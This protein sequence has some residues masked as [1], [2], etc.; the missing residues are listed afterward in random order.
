MATVKQGARIELKALGDAHAAM[1]TG[2]YWA[3]RLAHGSKLDYIHLT[4]MNNK[5]AWKITIKYL[6]N[7]KESIIENTLS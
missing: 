2:K 4:H 1:L 3:Q 6:P 5:A 7:D